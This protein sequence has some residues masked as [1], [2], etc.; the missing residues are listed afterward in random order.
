MAWMEGIRFLLKPRLKLSYFNA[1]HSL[2][3]LQIKTGL[4]GSKLKLHL[5]FIF[6]INSEIF[7][8]TRH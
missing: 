4:G 6:T 7:I 5:S 1:A 2:H 3:A 8:S